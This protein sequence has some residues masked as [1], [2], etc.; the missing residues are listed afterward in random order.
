MAHKNW[1]DR[2][3]PVGAR[4]RTFDPDTG[5]PTIATVVNHYTRGGFYQDTHGVVAQT[6]DTRH[7][8]I[9]GSFLDENGADRV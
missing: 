2:E 9:A 6:D 1:I 5:E 3:Y 7:F 8:R 4:I